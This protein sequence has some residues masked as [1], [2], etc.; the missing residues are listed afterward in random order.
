MK[1]LLF[2][3]V[4]ALSSILLSAQQNPLVESK[5]VDAVTGEVLPFASVYIST[6]QGTISNQ[7]GGFAIAAF[8]NDV[9]HISYVGYESRDFVA[10]KLPATVKLKPLSVELSEVLVKPVNVN[11]LLMR[12]FQKY[13]KQIKQSKKKESQFFYR[14]ITRTNTEC[15]EIME[16][17]YNACSVVTV[18]NI[19]LITGRYACL[20]PDSLHPYQT[21]TNF[22]QYSQVSPIYLYEV[23]YGDVMTFLD[24]HYQRYYSVD[25]D[26][27]SDSNNK[28]IYR[29][30]FTPRSKRRRLALVGVLYIDPVTLEIKRMECRE[31]DMPITINIG[32]YTEEKKISISFT[33]NYK[34]VH[35]MS[36]IQ[37]VHVKTQYDSQLVGGKVEVNSILYNMG[38]KKSRGCR[39]LARETNMLKQIKNIDY[40]PSFWRSN[41]IIK[42]TPL[43]ENATQIFEKANLF[44]TYKK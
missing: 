3:F 42:R 30:K 35:G 38:P 13:K 7:D 39:F 23:N 37:T 25:Y 36:V 9:L 8:P 12:I 6:D 43:E 34:T 40:S 24:R 11:D 41:V 21:F 16:A 28:T 26:I 29:L 33:L 44:G 22:F 19:N 32:E 2:L 4:L 17:F 18:R 10:S 27:L 31:D 15:N 20:Q 5:I 1:K 14:Q